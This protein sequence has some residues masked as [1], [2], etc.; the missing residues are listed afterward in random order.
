[1]VVL[2]DLDH[3]VAGHNH[4]GPAI[5]LLWGGRRIST[6]SGIWNH[7]DPLRSGKNIKAANGTIQAADAMAKGPAPMKDNTAVT[8]GRPKTIRERRKRPLYHP[9]QAVYR[10]P[11]TTA[12][13]TEVALLDR[14]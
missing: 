4:H 8:M 2:I 12:T 3:Q 13:I 1:M 9:E 11:T 6:A 14:K 5:D 10:A 7:L